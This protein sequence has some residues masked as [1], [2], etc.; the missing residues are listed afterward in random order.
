MVNGAV[1]FCK[2]L[3]E[4]LAPVTLSVVLVVAVEVAKAGF[5]V[6]R[7]DEAVEIEMEG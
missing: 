3:V 6:R 2:P 4:T 1:S 7:G 5:R